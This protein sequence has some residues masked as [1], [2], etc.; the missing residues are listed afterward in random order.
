MQVVPKS[1]NKENSHDL[2]LVLKS[3]N[4][5]PSPTTAPPLSLSLLTNHISWTYFPIIVVD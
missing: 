2:D 3:N 5:P 4:L 1:V